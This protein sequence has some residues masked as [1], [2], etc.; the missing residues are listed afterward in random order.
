MKF[1][2]KGQNGFSLMELMIVV[3]IIGVLA[4]IAAPKLQV[5]MAKSRT[6]EAK[7]N[8]GTMYTLQH[9]YFADSA[10]FGNYNQIG[11][12]E[13]PNNKYAYAVASNSTTAFVV[14]ATAGSDKLCTGSTSDV[15]NMNENAN[16]SHQTDGVKC[17]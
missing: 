9:A 11:F 4:S 10:T 2:M 13:P 17:N 8:L 6:A 5:F 15:W 1:S 12:K 16:L 3:G 7:T 14:N